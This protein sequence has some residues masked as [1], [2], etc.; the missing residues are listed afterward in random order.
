MAKMFQEIEGWFDFDDIYE[1]ALRR[2]SS[3]KPARFVEIG[4][5]KG[6]SSCYLAERI[7]ETGKAIRLD[8]VD[9]FAGDPD[10]GERDLWPE[11]AA[12]LARA[13]V[14]PRVQSHRCASLDAAP[15]FADGSLDFVFLDARHTFEDVQRDLAAWWPKLG[16]GGLFA[17]HDYGYSPG[18]QAAVDAFVA[19]HGF[20]HAFRTSGASWLIY[21]SLVVDAAYCLSLPRRA[22][23]RQKAAA[24]LRAAG[25]EGSVT[26]FDA[27]DGAALDHPHVVSDGQAGCAAS[28]L[29][30]LRAASETGH[31]HVLIFED[32]VELVPDFLSR[33]ATS[34][35][36]CP[37]AYDLC[38]VG[39]LC[40]ET[41]GNYLHPFDEYVARVGSVCG[42]HAYIANLEALPEIEAG[43]GGLGRVIDD[44]Y[45]AWFA[46][47]GD[48]YAFVPYLAFQAAGFSD[49]AQGHNANA[50]H[51]H[52]VWR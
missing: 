21:K 1:L 23:R 2:S 49:V 16:P 11:F 47:R 19:A 4:A 5:Y 40:V 52:Y 13:G 18:V 26:F 38:Y 41:W 7:A 25:L 39:A 30:A 42:T 27:I 50:A 24:Q 36:R 17:G 46:P 48:T 32:D 6:R 43:L 31:R 15:R 51:A 10:V 28:H 44:W 29:A 20:Q 34:L 45:A 35:A 14:L 37:S 33:M 9:T 3:R 12:N 8:V 22:D